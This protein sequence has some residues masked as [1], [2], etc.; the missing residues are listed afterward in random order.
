MCLAIPLVVSG[1]IQGVYLAVLSLAALTSFEAVAGLPAAAQHLQSNFQSAR[2]LFEVVDA[3]PQVQDP[4]HPLPLPAQFDLQVRDLSFRYPGGGPALSGLS[5]DLPPGKRLAIVG[6]SGAGK[7]T[8]L[9]LLLRFW[10]FDEGQILWAGRDLRE[11]AQN[12]IRQSISVVPQ[13]PYLFSAS[14]RENLRMANPSA[15]EQQVVRGSRSGRISTS[16]SCLCR[17]DMTPGSASRACG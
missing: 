7:S 14:L 6:P 12:D 16:L 10:D 1:Q 2:R 15:S 8:L 4:P 17:R 3:L 9:S 13:R 5:F 11:Y